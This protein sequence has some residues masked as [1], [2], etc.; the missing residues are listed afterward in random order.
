MK[1]VSY[2]PVKR[3][4]IETPIHTYMHTNLMMRKIRREICW[5]IGKY[6][7]SVVDGGGQPTSFDTSHV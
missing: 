2:F 7:D 3:K 4:R 5:F 1:Q 6:Y